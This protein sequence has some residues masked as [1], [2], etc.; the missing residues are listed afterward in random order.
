MTNPEPEAVVCPYCRAGVTIVDRA[1]RY[2]W[3]ERLYA[4]G[5]QCFMSGLPRPF[6]GTSEEDMR[7]KAAIVASLAVMVQDEDPG[8]VWSYLA[9]M[10]PKFVRELAQLAFAAVPID[11]KT[12]DDIWAEWVIR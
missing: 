1:D 11:G 10:P 6:T 5:Q 12:V 7:R 8:V 2:S 9:A 4:P 3:H